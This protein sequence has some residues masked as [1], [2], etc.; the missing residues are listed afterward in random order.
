MDA[1]VHC[2][3]L[4]VPDTYKTE[5]LIT[6]ALERIGGGQPLAELPFVGCPWLK[7][8]AFPEV[9]SCLSGWWRGSL[10]EMTGC[11]RDTDSLPQ[12]EKTLKGH[13]IPSAPHEMN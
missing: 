2:P 6:P 12:F 10:C 8:A 3:I 4:F 5:I 1:I 13:Y 9:L 7:R 11:C